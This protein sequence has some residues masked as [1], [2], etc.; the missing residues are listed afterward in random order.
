MVGLMAEQFA[1]MA[2][3]YR[4]TGELSEDADQSPASDGRPKTPEDSA[5]RLAR[6]LGKDLIPDEMKEW[7]TVAKWAREQQLNRIQAACERVLAAGGLDPE[8][9]LVGAGVG[10]FLVERLAKRLGRQYRDFSDLVE[11]AE[12]NKIWA[13]Y[14]A[15]AYAVAA[16]CLL[17]YGL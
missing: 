17:Q 2:D 3:I 4:L 6:M 8:A 5:R 15:P 14:C 13:T 7:V 11:A 10:H 1:T 9:P 12:E 16:L